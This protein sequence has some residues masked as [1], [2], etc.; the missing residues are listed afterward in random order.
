[1]PLVP[2][3]LQ[4]LASLHGR[5][6]HI[7]DHARR[8]AVV[9]LPDLA[10]F[11]VIDSA[12]VLSGDPLAPPPQVQAA[13][14]DVLLPGKVGVAAEIEVCGVPQS[15]ERPCESADPHAE[16]SRLAVGVGSLEAE[17]NNGGGAWIEIHRTCPRISIA[18]P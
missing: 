16:T 14:L 9:P 7:L 12:A 15:G 5:L 18:S 13:A 17:N 8:Q 10:F 1:M 3:E 4:V 2:Q 6:H 11:A